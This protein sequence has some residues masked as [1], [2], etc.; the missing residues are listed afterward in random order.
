MG[1]CIKSTYFITQ[2]M[3]HGSYYVY[4]RLRGAP[5]RGFW[6]QTFALLYK[7]RDLDSYV[8]SICT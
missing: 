2:G 8:S 1:R 6:F 3:T 7:S 4:Y 5:F